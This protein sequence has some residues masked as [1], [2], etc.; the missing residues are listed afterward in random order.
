MIAVSTGAW[1]AAAVAFLESVEC[2][3]RADR[4]G[5]V[6]NNLSGAASAL[7]YAGRF[8]EAVPVAT[9]GLALARALGMPVLINECLVALAQSLSRQD[10]ERASALLGEAAHQDL[11]YEAYSELIRMTLAA[12]MIGDWPLTARIATRSIPHAHWMNHRPYLH[13]T[14]TAAARALADNDAEAAA[15]IQG[16]AHALLAIP[17]PTITPTTTDAPPVPAQGGSANGGGLIVDIRRETSRL[18]VEALGD[19]QLRALRDHGTALDT[20]TAVAYTLSR[21]NAFLASTDD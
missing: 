11:D 9:E 17:A 12:A 13:G 5:Y 14:L 6:A 4:P 1:D 2:Y 20:D 7:C 18:L 19:E 21:L 10:P 16:A 15:T 3:R 8:A